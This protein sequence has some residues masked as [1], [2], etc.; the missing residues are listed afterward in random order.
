MEMRRPERLWPAVDGHFSHNC[1]SFMN[2]TVPPSPTWVRTGR[3]VDH[4]NQAL[5]A[6]TVGTVNGR[7]RKLRGVGSI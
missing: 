6:P 3:R 5:P 4:P 1:H 7:A 2:S